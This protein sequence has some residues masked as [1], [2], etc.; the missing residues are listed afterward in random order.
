[1][2]NLPQG[3]VIVVASPKAGRDTDALS[4]IANYLS[5]LPARLANK[6]GHGRYLLLG[7]FDGALRELHLLREAL[8]ARIAA[9]DRRVES[10]RRIDGALAELADVLD[11]LRSSA[12]LS[13]MQT[14]S[15]RR[16]SRRLHAAVRKAAALIVGFSTLGSGLYP[17]A[18]PAAADT[19]VPAYLGTVPDDDS[20]MDRPR[21]E[22]DAKGIPL[23]GFR[24]FPTLDLGAAFDDN[25]YLQ[26][27]GTAS[28]VSDFRFE[29]AP[30]IHIKSE[31]GRH[32]LE[33]YGSADN[34]NY[35]KYDKLNLTDWNI[36]GNG[37][38]DISRQADL[39]AAVSYGE[40]HEQ[41]SSPSANATPSTL[42][43]P[44]SPN[45]YYKTHGEAVGH[46]LINRLGFSL[47][48]SYDRFSWLN[49]PTLGGGRLFNGDRNQDE[50][51][52]YARVTYDFSPGYFAYVKGLYDSRQ[53]DLPMDRTGVDRSSHGFRV[54]AGVNLKFSHLVAGEIFVGY[55]DQ[56]FKAPLKDISGFD[57]GIGLDWFATPILTVHLNGSRIINDVTLIGVNASD[58]KSIRLSADYEFQRDV[59]VQAYGSY[60]NSRLHSYLVAVSRNDNYPG[61]GIGVK[62]LMNRY[63]SAN[64]NYD[65]NARSSNFTGVSY[66]DNTVSLGLSLHI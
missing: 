50:Y 3:A 55:L 56:S 49:T 12:R 21:P 27:T 8:S 38:Y 14:L 26:P 54:D 30:A 41:L 18:L 28:D 19:T 51:Q 62:Y 40:Y 4:R 66:T 61:A 6:S 16:T 10:L 31:W 2:M 47:G 5:L 11:G 32:S 15:G 45:R 35:A 37:R 22:Y 34:V 39:T 13:A 48:G 33:V 52:G 23:G 59:I 29:E 7:E 24:M 25:I 44:E 42:N 36:G 46:Y 9:N 17:F 57:Y 60:T 58:E 53:F 1:M 20:V 64:L 65:Y 43:F 63:M